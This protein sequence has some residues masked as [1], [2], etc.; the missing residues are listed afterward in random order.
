M[1]AEL[2][3][4]SDAL[5]H[6]LYLKRLLYH[7]TG[8]DYQLNLKLDSRCVINVVLI[9]SRVLPKGRSMVLALA[10]LRESMSEDS[11]QLEHVLTKDNLADELTKPIPR[12]KF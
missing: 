3:A 11:I 8:L 2:A 10:H 6:S 12:S 1:A 9:H 7:I 4:A 5:T